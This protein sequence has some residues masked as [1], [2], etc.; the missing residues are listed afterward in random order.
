MEQFW[1]DSSIRQIIAEELNRESVTNDM[2]VQTESHGS[3]RP[4]VP[5]D[6]RKEMI[7]NQR[8]RAKKAKARTQS[9]RTSPSVD[10]QLNRLNELK[11][12]HGEFSRSPTDVVNEQ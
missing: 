11:A 12:E 6:A 5:R 4:N 1:L 7:E 10:E 3:N 2:T 8:E 9:G